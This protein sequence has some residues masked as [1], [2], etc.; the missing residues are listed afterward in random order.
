MEGKSQGTGH[1]RDKKI[2]RMAR[3]QGDKNNA[4]RKI[5]RQFGGCL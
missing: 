2:G 5:R 4:I 1:A 3:C